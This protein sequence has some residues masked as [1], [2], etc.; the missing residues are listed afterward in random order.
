MRP[1][2]P[3]DHRPFS[4]VSKWFMHPWLQL[5]E[6]GKNVCAV[7]WTKEKLS[8][9]FSKVLFN[10]LHLI[11]LDSHQILRVSDYLNS[12]VQQVVDELL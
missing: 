7:L 8:V 5:L 3:S 1:G 10:K 11:G 4:T 6:E 9:Q 12:R 2:I